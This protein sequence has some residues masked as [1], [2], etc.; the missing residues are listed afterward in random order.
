MSPQAHPTMLNLAG[1]PLFDLNPHTLTADERTS[2]A[3]ARARLI[4]RSYGLSF[5]DVLTFSPKFW[6]MH[7]DPVLPLD[8]G[9]FTIIAAHVNLTVGTI[10]RHLPRRLDLV[11]LVK[12][13]LSL[14]TVGVYLLSERG[15]GLDA[16]NI[17]TTATK[18]NGGYI[19]HTPRE[20][21][22][23]FMPAT[24][25]AFGVPKVALVMARLVIDGEDLGSRFFIVPLCDARVMCP[26]VK[27]IRLPRRSGTSPLDF[28]MTM[29][30]HVFLPDN[31]LLGSSVEASAGSRA[32]WWDEVW[33]IPYGS[34][35]VAGPCIIGL[36][37]VAYIGAQYSLNRRILAHGAEPMPII[38]FPT[39]Q[40][41]VLHALASAYVLDAWYR[42]VIPIMTDDKVD[43]AVKHGMA[44]VVKATACRQ[45]IQCTREMAERCGAQGTFD[46][47]FMARFE[48]DVRGI[49][50]AE[51]DVLVLCIRLFSELLLGRYELPLP[52]ASDSPFARLAHAIMDEHAQGLA[53]LP[54]GHRSAAAGYYL[55]PQ[56]ER[57]VTALGHAMALAAARS[58]RAVPA[59]LLAVYEAGVVRAY[60][61]WF[62]ESGGV[63]LAAQRE[64]EADA[65]RAAVGGV[66]R[67][68]EGL[69]VAE[70]VRASI[71]GDEAWADT[72]RQLVA[73]GGESERLPAY[74]AAYAVPEVMEARARL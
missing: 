14:D 37:H 17:E 26:G 13:L 32:I 34:M 49:V 44:V 59:P 50:I 52:P 55:L 25:P 16:F 39:Q 23:K 24:T 15:H 8:I 19:L 63:P 46:N 61:G 69:G 11:P 62:A 20:E 6:D 43:H 66:A 12:S 35:T 51:G 36:K 41:A 33:R 40:W 71:V 70:Y 73:Y 48:A 27:S 21:A 10:A 57:A 64:R 38:T 72:V 65:L 22:A 67:Y 28:S 29:F 2:L 45:V 56:A 4:I 53:A 1:H 74:S 54:G 9:C 18:C 31:A 7:L 58:S 42:S 60:S 47:N 68:A 5:T 3:Y 30:D